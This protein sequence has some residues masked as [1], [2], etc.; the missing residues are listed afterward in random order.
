MYITI[1]HAHS[2]THT[3][4]HTLVYSRTRPR[5]KTSQACPSDLDISCWCG[6]TLLTAERLT[7]QKCLS[8]KS[9]PLTPLPRPSFSPDSLDCKWGQ[10][11]CCWERKSHHHIFPV[12]RRCA[13]CCR[14]SRSHPVVSTILQRH[15]LHKTSVIVMMHAAH[16]LLPKSLEET[17][18]ILSISM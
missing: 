6:K 17:Q 11:G 14:Q 15:G 10:S 16:S 4:G 5:V 7:G 13:E 1:S 8:H 9:T 18:D 2:R 3:L 12:C